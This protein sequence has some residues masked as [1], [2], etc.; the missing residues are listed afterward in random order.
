M[1]AIPVQT[2]SGMRIAPRAMKAPGRGLSMSARRAR[3]IYFSTIVS[4]LL[5]EQEHCMLAN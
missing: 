1:S 4:S 5:V 2:K 3:Q